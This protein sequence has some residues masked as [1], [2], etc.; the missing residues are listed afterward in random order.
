MKSLKLSPNTAEGKHLRAADWRLE[1]IIHTIGEYRIEL[2]TNEYKALVNFIIGQQLSEKASNTIFQRL[3]S[4]VKQIEPDILVKIDDSIF[5]S[6]G[7]S[8]MK[9]VFIKELSL[10]I[11]NNEIDLKILKTENEDLIL[12]KLTA[13][14]GIGKWTAEMFL[15]FCLGKKD[16]MSIQDVGLQRSIKWLYKLKD[17]PD[18]ELMIKISNKWKPYRTIAS[19][20]LWEII[21]RDLIS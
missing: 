1:K 21:N 17:N 14:N 9:T 4:S 20:Y 2:Y 12:K 11:V 7:I 3:H 16:V 18:K 8:K 15:I 6:A 19:L 5:R 10:K 13:I